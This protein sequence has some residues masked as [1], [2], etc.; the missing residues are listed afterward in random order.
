[1]S[2]ARRRRRRTV[3]PDTLSLGSV[4]TSG[5]RP[6][7]IASTTPGANSVSRSTRET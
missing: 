7:R 2:A 6:F 1:M 4:I 5:C 3:K